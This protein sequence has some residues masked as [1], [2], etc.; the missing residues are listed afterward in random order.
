MTK[1][2][3]KE[4]NKEFDFTDK[5]QEEILEYIKSLT[6]TEDDLLKSA[7]AYHVI[8]EKDKAK[9]IYFNVLS[10]N[11]DKIEAYLGIADVC[12]YSGEY[13]KAIDCLLRADEISEN[14]IDILVNLATN[15]E[16]VDLNIAFKYYK[17]IVE[18]DDTYAGAYI[19]IGRIYYYYYNDDKKALEY[20]NK[21]IE[22]NRESHIFFNARGTL[23]LD[24]N[25]YEDAIYD[26]NKCIELNKNYTRAYIKKAE[27]LLRLS[28]YGKVD[29][30]E[31][32]S[33]LKKAEST[34]NS[35]FL[36]YLL[37]GIVFEKIDDYISAEK[38]YKKH[39]ELF[40][41]K[42]VYIL[43]AK[44]YIKQDKTIEA[45]QLLNELGYEKYNMDFHKIIKNIFEFEVF[46]I[47][48][49]KT[50]PR[51]DKYRI[52]RIEELADYLYILGYC[53]E[54]IKLYEL[55]CKKNK[56]D[57]QAHIICGSMYMK[58]GQL[59]KALYYFKKSIKI[60]KN[61]KFSFNNIGVIYVEKMKYRKALNVFKNL[62][63]RYPDYANPIYNMATIYYDLKEYDNAKTYYKKCL[64]IKSADNEIKKNATDMLNEISCK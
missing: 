38:Y 19:D 20:Y 22:L 53:S 4:D 10:T 11:P 33:L 43:L 64:E 31:I 36:L 29:Y 49:T 45:K 32:I 21:G 42:S 5:S 54:T 40:Y 24:I 26:F 12:Y 37:K 25:S 57:S 6:N 3:K 34:K 61:N 30:E 52:S 41:D 63:K 8:D 59:D 15:Y 48:E 16:Y 17:K 62:I 46:S 2:K 44:L 58:N 9:E 28:V 55:K 35:E 27:I 7:Y 14:N 13:L 1:L 56:N 60:D 39:I 47:K 51:Y 18:L 23:Y 50:F